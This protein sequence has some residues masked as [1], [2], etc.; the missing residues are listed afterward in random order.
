MAINTQVYVSG[1]I[2]EFFRAECLE[3][4]GFTLGGINVDVEYSS[5]SVSAAAWPNLV[6]RAVIFSLYFSQGNE[7][8][9]DMDQIDQYGFDAF[10]R[11]LYGAT[12]FFTESQRV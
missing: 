11:S 9:S 1:E 10:M 6:D 8:F 4:T 3:R 2:F 12:E 5:V 7:A